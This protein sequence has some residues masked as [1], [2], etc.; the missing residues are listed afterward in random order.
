M[1][2]VR[3]GRVTDVCVETTDRDEEQGG[4]SRTRRAAKAAMSHLLRTVSHH[5]GDIMRSLKRQYKT[6]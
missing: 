5:A 6:G 1:R 2:L 3:K 4:R